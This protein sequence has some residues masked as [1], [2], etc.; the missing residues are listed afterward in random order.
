MWFPEL[1]A[2]VPFA[3]ASAQCLSQTSRLWQ[4]D[5]WHCIWRI[6][7]LLTPQM[8]DMNQALAGAIG[9]VEIEPMQTLVVGVTHWA[10]GE[11]G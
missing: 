11:I 7:T 6:S 10:T 9:V 5:L 3:I 1:Q 8:S 2:V 4:Y